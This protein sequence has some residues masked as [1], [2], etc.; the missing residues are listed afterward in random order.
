MKESNFL[1]FCGHS[2]GVLGPDRFWQ[3][4]KEVCR[5]L[6]DEDYEFE[7]DEQEEGELLLFAL[8]KACC[9]TVHYEIWSRGEQPV[10]WF[11]SPNL[12]LDIPDEVNHFH[13]EFPSYLFGLEEAED[14]YSA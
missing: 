7:G 5:V 1:I 2:P 13:D 6:D 8:D 9:N 4:M 11:K 10:A 12:E 14:Y 3:I